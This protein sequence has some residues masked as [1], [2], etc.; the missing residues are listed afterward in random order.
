MMEVKLEC[1]NVSCEKIANRLSK[2]RETSPFGYKVWVY[3]DGVF[4]FFRVESISD[5]NELANRL[6]RIKEIEFTFQQIHKA[7]G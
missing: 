1:K 3:K 6:K 5:L 4:A 7:W 2:F